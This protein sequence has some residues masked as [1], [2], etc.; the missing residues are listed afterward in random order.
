[1]CFCF[2]IEADLMTFG[3]GIGTCFIY[4]VSSNFQ[5]MY[6]K[7]STS[8]ILIV[9]K[10]VVKLLAGKQKRTSIEYEQH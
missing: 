10:W 2:Y 1:M 6:A 7:Q 4:N 9:A 5:R 8:D 3:S